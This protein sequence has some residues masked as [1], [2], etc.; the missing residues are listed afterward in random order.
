MNNNFH[1]GRLSAENA[2]LHGDKTAF[3]KKNKSTN[4]W[5]AVSW[6]EIDETVKR[7]A[8][9][10]IANG[11]QVQDKVGIFSQ[12][13]VEIVMVDLAL[14]S[15]RAVAVPMYATQ[16]ADQ[17]AY[18]AKDAHTEI[19]FAGEQFQFNEVVKAINTGDTP[20]RQIVGIDPSID[21]QGVTQ[22]IRWNDFIK[23][24]EQG[25][26]SAEMQ[27]RESQL[28]EDDL[29]LLI[30]TSGTTGEPKGVM[31]THENANGCLRIHKARLT[32]LQH[33]YTS[34]CFLPLSHIFERGWTYVCMANQMPI[35]INQNPKEIQKTLREV[36]PQTMCAVPRFWEKV[37][38][39]VNEKIDSFPGLIRKFARH[40]ISVG[41]Q[42]NL[43]HRMV[44]KEPSFLL[45]LRYKFY[46]KTLFQVLKK[47]VGIDKG[48]L[49]PCAG[50]AINEK[51]NAFMHSVGINLVVGYGL[52]ETFATVT[53]CNE[54][55]HHYN[56]KTCG[57]LMDEI[58][59]KID[60]A[61]NEILL[62]GKTITK[63]YYNKPE[64]NK[65]SF[66]EDGFFRTGDAGQIIPGQVVDGKTRPQ[67]LIMIERIK[68]L[69]K[70]SN[71]KYIAPQQIE[72]LIEND[73]YIEQSCIVAND[74]K[75]VT[76]LIVPAYEQ[77][78]NVAREKGIAFSNRAELLA[79]EQIYNFIAQRIASATEGIAAYEQVKYFTLLEKPFTIDNG[80][81]TNTLKMKRK[82][83]YKDY[84]EAIEEMYKH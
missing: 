62:K 32:A 63:G 35:Y 70:T 40:A 43:G 47:A 74:R 65:E 30:Y 18:I 5:D 31:L 79:N 49:F 58:E 25:D 60:P 33:N 28:N 81:L 77:L 3:F 16:T 57:E 68:E 29:A 20:I 9:A 24:A 22:A 2:R 45:S 36:H 52:T 55:N 13:M 1:L 21:F 14:Q 84:A 37:Y 53:C 4:A 8:A 71:G 69:F 64:A 15:I 7:L 26:F 75:Y 73:K 12:N 11:V 83:I 66:T 80:E 39:G 72:M 6:S 10:F 78:E 46:E 76:A 27:T 54:E 41:E 82:V 51:V 34:L 50:S 17:V 59:I 44:G 56:M 38:S 42:Y 48:M 67:Q 61:N 23:S 19:I